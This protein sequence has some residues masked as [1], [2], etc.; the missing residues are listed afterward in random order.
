MKTVIFDC[1]GTLVDS[2]VLSNRVLVEAVAEHG[3][4]LSVEDAI[5]SF[6]G[7]RMADCVAQL[8]LR[9]GRP[10]PPDFVPSFRAR[11]ADAFRTSLR[12]VDGALELVRSLSPSICVASSGPAEKIEL[13]LSL[14]GLLP[15]FEGRIFSSY[16]VGSWKPDPG[17]FLHAARVM[18]VTPADCAV[19]EDSMLGIRAGLAAGMNVFAF[20]PHDVDARIPAGVTVVKQLLELQSLLRRGAAEPGVVDGRDPRSRADSHR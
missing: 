3:L 20:Q 12:P 4:V 6:R 13:T 17:L 16:D 10:L 1:D 14:T 9:L 18:G 19:V 5:A 7:G 8:E 2:E 15:F 11:M